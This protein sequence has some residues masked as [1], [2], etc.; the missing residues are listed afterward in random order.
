MKDLERPCSIRPRL[1]SS[2]NVLRRSVE[3]ATQCRHLDLIGERLLLGPERD[4]PIEVLLA[5]QKLAADLL[6]K[7]NEE[8]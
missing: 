3:P 1:R 4:F 8:V 7:I 5:L 2:Q 6:K